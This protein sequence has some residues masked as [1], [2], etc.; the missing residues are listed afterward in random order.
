MQKRNAPGPKAEGVECQLAGDI[1]AD[2][3]NRIRV[4]FLAR[5]GV[6]L[7]RAGLIAGLALGECAGHAWCEVAQ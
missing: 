2:S 6:P 1:D 7:H 4:Q 3:T 5:L